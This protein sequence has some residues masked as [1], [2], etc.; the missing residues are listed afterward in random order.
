MIGFNNLRDARHSLTK[1]TEAFLG[2]DGAYFPDPNI[3][4]QWAFHWNFRGFIGEEIDRIC[5][6]NRVTQAELMLHYP[7]D[8]NSAESRAQGVIILH[9]RTEKKLFT[10][11]AYVS[12][13]FKPAR[14]Q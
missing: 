12:E 9:I 1:E 14:M 11:V 2:T 3:F 6:L 8:Q 10:E 13:S 7:E 5:A 4:I